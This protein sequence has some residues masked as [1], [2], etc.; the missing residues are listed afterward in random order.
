MMEIARDG[1]QPVLV[2]FTRAA[3]PVVDLAGG[4]VVLDPPAGLLDPP[5]HETVAGAAHDLAR[6]RADAFPGDV[7]GPAGAFAAGKALRAG[8]WPLEAVDIRDFAHRQTPLGRRRAVRRRAGHGDAARRA[9][10]RH[11]RRRRGRAADLSVAARQPLD[12]ARV[13]ELAAG[14]GVRPA[15]RPL[16][17]RRRAGDR[18]PRR[19]R[20]SA[21]AISCCRAARS[22]RSR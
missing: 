18:R 8:L 3:V 6:H 2:P 13:R 7:A 19:S 10:S 20:K 15:L 1:G 12:Q 4:R 5:R 22:R 9:R 11:R 21:S 14:P 16:R 17:G